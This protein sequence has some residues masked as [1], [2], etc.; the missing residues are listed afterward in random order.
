MGIEPGDTISKLRPADTVSIRHE[1]ER[2]KQFLYG[3]APDR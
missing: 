2:K 3:N 1:R